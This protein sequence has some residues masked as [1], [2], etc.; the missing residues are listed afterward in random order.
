MIETLLSIDI[1]IDPTIINK[2]GIEITWHGLFTALGVVIGV[3]VAAYFGRKAG[4]KEDH[5]Y[6]AALA[7]VIGGI[8]GA[9]LLYVVENWSLFED[10]ITKIIEVNTGGISIYGALIGG[11]VGG[12]LYCIIAKVPDIPKAADIGAI[13]GIIGMAVGR[14]GDIINGEHFAKT[15]DLF[16]GVIYTNAN[17]P[18]FIRF[19]SAAEPQHPAV[20]YE[21]LGDLVIFTV[22]IY[23]YTHV[24]RSG[25]TFFAWIFLY[26]ALRFA[27]SFL[28]LDDT[29]LGTGLRTAQVIG[30]GGMIVGALGIIYLLVVPPKEEAGEGRAARRRAQREESPGVTEE[31]AT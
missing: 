19:G 11:L 5:I 6:N 2:W 27:V 15:T 29:I 23:L 4:Y 21:L 28:R 7:L 10:D 12:W 9:R 3:L 18:S 20:A 24:K 16:W 26:G 30:V 22:L 25:I 13:G 31:P 14:I 17:S 1:G 8:I